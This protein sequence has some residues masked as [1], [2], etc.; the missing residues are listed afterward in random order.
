MAKLLYRLGMFSARRAKTIIF[1]W[2]A[3]LA[4]AVG[5]FL[6][7]GGQLSDQISMPDL[8]TTEVADRMTEELDDGSGGSA[9]VVIRTEDGEEFTTEQQDAIAELGTEIEEHDIVTSVTDPFETAD[10]VEANRADMESGRQD[11]AEGADQLE[12]GQEELDAA[13]QELQAGQDELDAA[14][15]QAEQSGMAQAVQPQLD[16]QQEELDAGRAEL[17]AAQEELET[18]RQDLEDGQLELDRGQA[19]LDLSDGMGTVSDD[20]DTALM[21]INFPQAAQELDMEEVTAVSQTLVDADIDGVE[22]LPTQDLSFEMPAMFSMAEVI[23][24]LVA[25][26]VLLVMLGTFIGAGLPLLNALIGVG[27]GV[28]GAMSL[29]GAIEMMSITPILGLMLG[30]AVGID[31]SLFIL[32][33]H[34]QQLKG[35]MGVTDSIALANGT[36]GNAVIFAGA[37]VV[38]ALLALNVTGVGFL[39]MMGT[40]A[41]FCVLVAALMAVTMTPALLSVTGYTI[42]SKKERRSAGRAKAR[43]Q[44]HNGDKVTSGMRTG[45]TVLAT[46]GAVA[47]LIFLALPVGSLRLGLPDASQEP[48]DSTAYQAYQETEESFGEGM[49]SPLLVLADLPDSDLSEGEA[50]DQ[51]I[52]VAEHLAERDDVETAVPTG[53]ND[54]HSVIA[55]AIVPTDGP[56]SESTENLVHELRADGVLADTEVADVEL[57]VAGAAA[58][59]IDISDVVADALP[60]YLAVVI[61][62]SLLL[63]IMVFRS[64]LL[65]LVATL[66]FVGSFAATMGIIVAIFQWGWFGDVFDITGT[67]P[68]LTF[69]PILVMGILF[70]LSMDYQLFTATGMREAYVQGSAPKVAVRKGLVAGRAVVTAA[71]LIMISVFAGFVFTDDVM[72]TSIGLALAVGVLLDAFV[73][74]LL[75][76]PSVLHLL[77]PA[78]WWLPKWIDRI[79]PD[80]D[81]EGAALEEE[82]TKRSQGAGI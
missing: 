11:L 68:I 56:A 10:E 17:D 42:L 39:G 47:L 9:N 80:V 16:A 13:R 54:D 2:L 65:P 46:V 41:A 49:N 64:L 20:G 24:L 50:T 75:L 43:P 8:E 33:R 18:S 21:M 4:V 53:M 22:V 26:V 77:G 28:A 70:G 63:M 52:A 38:I 40:V 15:E 35:G 82:I 31:Y 36:S 3:I 74:R 12:T 48:A 81:V 29:S 23:G 57:S 30:L 5:S 14:A 66:G 44:Q 7:F 62:L 79:L 71:A 45:N 51:Q 25:A 34:R 76:V 19:M 69:L 59:S 1:A 6:T 55:L 78:A 67:G 32:H 60:V 61:G 37:T 58:A 72:I 27:I 73:V